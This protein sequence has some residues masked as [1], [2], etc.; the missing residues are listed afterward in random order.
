MKI[1][2]TAGKMGSLANGGNTDTGVTPG[3]TKLNES[4]KSG[5]EKSFG[6][7]PPSRDPGWATYRGAWSAR[8]PIGEKQNIKSG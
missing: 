1:T 8:I 5:L 7:P 4:G 6:R 3:G 2:P